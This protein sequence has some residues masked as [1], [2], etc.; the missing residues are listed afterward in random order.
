MAPYHEMNGVWFWWGDKGRE[1]Y[2]KLW[3]MMYDRYTNYH[4]LNN[5]DLGLGRKRFYVTSRRWGPIPIITYYY[6]PGAG[7]VNILR[8]DDVYHFDYRQRLHNELLR[9]DP[10]AAICLAETGELPSLRFW[11]YS[12]DGAGLWCGQAGY[13][14]ITLTMG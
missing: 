9:A 13:G 2:Q 14:P 10:A 11:L 3:K 6:Y 4:T 1:R 12:P 7:Y 5:P 8:S